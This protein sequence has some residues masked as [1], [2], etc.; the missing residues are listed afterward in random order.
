MQWWKGSN[1]HTI[2][3][4]WNTYLASVIVLH[5]WFWI[6]FSP[7]ITV[8][9][10]LIKASE[11]ERRIQF[12]MLM[13]QDPFNSD[14]CLCS[15]SFSLS[16]SAWDFSRAFLADVSWP[17]NEVTSCSAIIFA[18]RHS[19]LFWRASCRQKVHDGNSYKSSDFLF[20]IMVDFLKSSI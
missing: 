9:K 20:Y 4:L 17:C 1:E 16:F 13:N 7:K 10:I 19:F 8:W 6:R 18:L 14:T 5:I 2:S 3:V 11:V 12:A 15:C